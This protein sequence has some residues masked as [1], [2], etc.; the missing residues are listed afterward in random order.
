MPDFV[1]SGQI[2]T[3]GVQYLILLQKFLHSLKHSYSIFIALGVAV[4]TKLNPVCIG[5]TNGYAKFFTGQWQ[6]SP[7]IFKQYDGFL[8]DFPGQANVPL[9]VNY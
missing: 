6:N 2:T 3:L 4:I 9:I 7:F 8:R 5:A 1:Q